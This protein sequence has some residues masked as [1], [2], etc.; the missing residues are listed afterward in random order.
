[1]GGRGDG[2]GGGEGSEGGG[3]GR[4]GDGFGGRRISVSIFYRL[5]CFPFSFGR[6]KWDGTF[7]YLWGKH[8]GGREG[9]YVGV[10]VR[11]KGGRGR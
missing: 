6:G 5:F 1:M 10:D 3:L 2:T 4:G 7:V 8:L 9:R 11:W